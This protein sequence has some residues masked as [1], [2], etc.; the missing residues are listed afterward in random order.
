MDLIITLDVPP[1]LT[2]GDITDLVADD[3]LPA[4][5]TLYQTDGKIKFRWTV[6]TN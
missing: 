4:N 5:A 6:T 1:A 2:A 3:V